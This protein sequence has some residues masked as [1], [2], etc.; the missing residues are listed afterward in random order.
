MMKIVI[1]GAGF[2]GTQLAKKLI[3]EGNEVQIIE[4][5]QEKVDQFQTQLDCSI[6]YADGNNL[7]TLQ[8]AGIADADALVAVTD[9]D[10]INMIPCSL[11]DA[12]YPDVIKIARVRNYG[13]YV[14]QQENSKI[15]KETFAK[16]N[17][18]LYGIDFMINPDVAAAEAI[19]TAVEHGV[20]DVTPLGDGE[21][22]L[23]TVK[24]EP[25]SRIDGI[26]L[27]NIRN[28]TDKK[29]IVVFVEDKNGTTLPK[30]DTIL[31]AGTS[32]GVL[33]HKDNLQELL[34]LCGSETKSIKKVLL[35]G[36]GKIG[37]I[38]ADSIIQRKNNSFLAKLFGRKN[39]KNSAQRFVIVDNDKDSCD[40][41]RDRFPDSEVFCADITDED[42]IEEEGLDKFNLA[43]F[44]THNHELNLMMAAYFEALGVKNTI[45]LI[46]NSTFCSIAEKMGVDV[47]VPIRDTVVDSIISHLRGKSVTEVH[48]I[49]ENH[50]ILECDLPSSSPVV[51]KTL[52]EIAKPGDFL[53][54]LQK[55]AG[56]A[57]YELP[58]GDSELNVGDHLVLIIRSGD[59]K[60][61][62]NFSGKD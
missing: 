19:V 42:F 25:G 43:I 41:A 3:A 49:S 53:L 35:L 39:K 6:I 55:K 33:S 4:N 30:G 59:K 2:T 8:Q 28:L 57:H 40:I 23:T 44:A 11:V 27:K 12:I 38:V 58:S 45:A 61:L 29:M 5:N 34:S 15:Q 16:T 18:P 37:S 10:E 26:M 13:Y 54:L 50:E 21:Y 1:V 22:E 7:S 62:E 60:I 24:I 14:N 36:I 48:T 56:A 9:N 32:I 31:R 17:R 52:K 47:T 46:A 51:G 20:S